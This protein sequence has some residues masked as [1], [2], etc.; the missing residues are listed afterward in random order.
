MEPLAVDEGRA[1]T[2]DEARDDVLR[3]F[4]A[5]RLRES[6]DALYDRLRE[7]YDIVVEPLGART[8]EAPGESTTES[9]QSP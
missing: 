9:T 1:V 8:D 7:R 6:I 5:Q 3:D 2:L 4:E